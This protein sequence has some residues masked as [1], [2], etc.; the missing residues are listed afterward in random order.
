MADSTF[1]YVLL[2]RQSGLSAV[3]KRLMDLII[4]VSVL[5]C[6]L[7]V[8]LVIAL[9]VKLGDGGPI[10]HRRRVVGRR[11]DF[12][13][14]KFRTMCVNADEVIRRDPKLWAEFQ[15]NFKLKDDPRITQLGG[16]LRKT[17]LDELPQLWNVLRGEMSLVGPRCVTHDELQKYGELSH[18][19]LS[20][21]PGVSG[22]WQTEGRQKVSYAERVQMDMEYIANWTLLWDIKILLKTPKVVIKGEGAY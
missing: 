9:L 17:S 21:K 4:A 14:L 8:L 3:A 10:I 12:D 2:D 15:K 20:V 22:Y 1:D 7:P 5:I 19:L 11:G 6:L 13:F 16:F 18:A